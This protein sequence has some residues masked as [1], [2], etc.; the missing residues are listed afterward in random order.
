MRARR[1]VLLILFCTGLLASAPF[2]PGQSFMVKNYDLLGGN[3]L[4]RGDFN[5]DGV[6]D[7][8]SS[9]FEN[10][11]I[12]SRGD[13]TVAS[14]VSV[15]LGQG[16]GTFQAPIRSPLPDGASDAALGDFNHD[17]NLDLATISLGIPRVTVLLGNGDGTFG[18]AKVLQITTALQPESVTVGDFN[19]DGNLD[20]AVGSG[21]PAQP[22][23]NFEGVV[24]EPNTIS[25]FPGDGHGNFGAPL[26]ISGFGTG[27]LVQVRVADFNADGKQD[28][29]LATQTEV[30]ALLGD[31]QFG[32]SPN[33]LGTYFSVREV[34]PTDVNQDGATDLLVSFVGC[35]G[36]CSDI[37]VFLSTG[38]NHALQRSTTIPVTPS[39]TAAGSVA[40]SSTAPSSQAQHTNRSR[41]FSGFEA[42]PPGRPVAVDI[43]GDGINDIVANL[44]ITDRGF[45]AV[46]TW[47][48]KPDGTYQEQPREWVLESE[49]LF[50]LVPGDFNRDGKID[51]ATT[52]IS[53]STLTVLLNSTPKAACNVSTQFSAVTMCTPQDLAFVNSS[54]PIVAVST[55][56]Q[57]VAGNPIVAG[58]IYVDNALAHEVG[59]TQIDIPLSMPAGDHFLVAKFWDNAGGTNQTVR[60]I[61][62][63]DGAPGETCPTSPQTMTICA[64]TANGTFSSPLHVF[65][66]V[67]VDAPVTAF[68]VYIDDNLVHNDILHDSYLD[69]AFPLAAGPHHVVVQAFDAR[70]VVYTAARDIVI[71]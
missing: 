64:P 50:E 29:A 42:I 45:Q 39:S 9:S 34:T 63:F 43:N 10:V 66:A 27:P 36:S 48:G 20:I 59:G 16:D 19:G 60:H 47:L 58:Q 69:T 51:I 71:Q 2:L 55:P 33:Q 40:A 13:T 46:A 53:N 4:N 8:I 24:N 67:M 28:I 12:D 21:N 49:G 25:I 17:G 56:E 7:L 61:S 14:S 65:A 57:P 41:L 15:F 5:H 26:K 62:V 32:F 3:F 1:L 44:I 37:D 31:G 18:P 54:V 38:P 70:G 35:N 22:G 52:N 23:Q 6:L 30:I 68:Q 11:V